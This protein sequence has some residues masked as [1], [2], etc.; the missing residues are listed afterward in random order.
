MEE[1]DIIEDIRIDPKEYAKL[2]AKSLPRVIKNDR[3]FDRMVA[4]MEELD[5]KP[6]ATP[7]ENVLSELLLK[8]ITD[9]DE[10]HYPLPAN[11]PHKVLQH[12]METR[13]LRQADLVEVIGSR[14]QVSQIFNGTRAISKAQA[15][16]LAEFFHVTADLFI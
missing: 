2:L 9:Y 12:L 15:K 5:R 14:A 1:V 11:Q 13:N 7:E 3:E 10:A 4:Q 16:K 6:D 8:L